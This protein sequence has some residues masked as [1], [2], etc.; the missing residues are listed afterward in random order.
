MYYHG[1]STKGL[2][3]LLP[4]KSEHKKSYIYFSS[5]PIVAAFYM[6]HKVKRP[7]NWFP[8]G[9]S[10]SGIPTI[11]NIIPMHCQMSMKV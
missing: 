1:S 7:H 9:F 11:L 2:K 4:Y 3:V 5:N 6:V 8:Y 10:Q